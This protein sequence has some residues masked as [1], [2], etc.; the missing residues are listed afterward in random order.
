MAFEDIEVRFADG[1]YAGDWREDPEV[2]NEVD[3]DDELLSETPQSV[4][5]ALGFDPLDLD[6]DE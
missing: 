2:S 4:I 5:D 6:D 3:P 1:S